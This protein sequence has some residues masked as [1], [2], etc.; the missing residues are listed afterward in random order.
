MIRRK[1]RIPLLPNLITTG[2]V[3]AGFYSIIHSIHGDFKRAAW[4]VVIG[5][6]FDMLDGRI[7]RLTNSQ[8]EF[9][10]QYDSLS[11]L[12]TFGFAPA[13]LAYFW[14]LEPYGRVGWLGAFLF[15]VCAALRLAR[16]NVQGSTEEREYFQG[17]PSPGAAGVVV[18]TVLFHQEF[19]AG[20][21]LTWRP[22]QLAFMALTYILALLMVS[23]IRFR[24]FKT[25]NIR[26]IRP[27]QAL[28][29]GALIITMLAYSPELSLFL[30]GYTYLTMGIIETVF[31]LRKRSILPDDDEEADSD[32]GDEDGNITVLPS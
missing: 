3:F 28:V 6:V 17:I 7:A 14:A 11:D 10:T 9:G 24:S 23:G 21:H 12:C 27:F 15:V 1:R 8:S 4:A 26:G 5:G 13:L 18:A 31:V 19:W 22:A 30:M 20:Q 2:N 32:A 29:L 16:F 25:F